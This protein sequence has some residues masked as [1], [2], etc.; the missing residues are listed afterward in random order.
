MTADNERAGDPLREPEAADLVRTLRSY[1]VLTREQL[2]E[3]S[4]AQ[5]WVQQSFDAALKR[6]IADGSIKQLGAELFEIGP[7][8]PDLNEGR[9]DPP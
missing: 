9:F 8:A 2:L 6:G 4:G 5:R 1:G 7:D 3:R